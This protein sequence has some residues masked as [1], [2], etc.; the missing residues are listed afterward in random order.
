[1]KLNQIRAKMMLQWKKQNVKRLMQKSD[2]SKIR[3]VMDGAEKNKMPSRNVYK[4][5]PM[6]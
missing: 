1:M 5:I 2:S 4:I 3:D 6:K